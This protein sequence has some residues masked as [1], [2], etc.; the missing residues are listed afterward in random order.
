[1]P[2]TVKPMGIESF[3]LDT[4]TKKR[5]E[6]YAD[7]VD[8]SFSWIVRKALCKYLDDIDCKDGGGYER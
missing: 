3:R 7:K 1:M 4:P 6:V 5:A 2:R 8:R